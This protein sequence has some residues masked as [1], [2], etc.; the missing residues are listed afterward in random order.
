MKLIY[1]VPKFFCSMAVIFVR[2]LGITS[3]NWRITE[4]V[5]IFAIHVQD[6]FTISKRIVVARDRKNSEEV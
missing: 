5:R 2:L 4:L 3:L 1:I 6:T